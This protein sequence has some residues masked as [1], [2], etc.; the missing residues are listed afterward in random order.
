[1]CYFDSRTDNAIKNHWNSTMRRKYE[2]EEKL[3]I[4]LEGKRGKSKAR[5]QAC[6]PDHYSGI[7]P[8]NSVQYQPSASSF[9]EGS[10]QSTAQTALVG[11]YQAHAAV[12]VDVYEVNHIMNLD[13]Q[14]QVASA[15]IGQL[16]K[17]HTL[18]MLLEWKAL[19]VEGHPQLLLVVSAS[20]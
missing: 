4:S 12:S 5:A 1:M 13:I 9:S 16:I 8:M 6:T 3:S 19:C 18:S 14:V 11:E 17:L 2:S 20:E 10:Q 7:E 15:W